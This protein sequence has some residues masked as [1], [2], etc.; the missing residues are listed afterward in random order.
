MPVVGPGTSGR[1]PFMIT[2]SLRRRLAALSLSALL[3][4]PAILAAQTP[5]PPD[6]DE[7][8][9]IQEFFS[10]EAVYLQARNQV[11][12][13]LGAQSH[14]LSGMAMR[15]LPVVLEF[16]L[17]D[18]LQI[19]GEFSLFPASSQ[20][21]AGDSELEFG[22]LFGVRRDIHTL[23]IAAGFDAGMPV[24][25]EGMSFEPFVVVARSLGRLQIHASAGAE[26]GEERGY[27][28]GAAG[29]LPVGPLRLTLEATRASLDGGSMFV[30]PG[31]IWASPFGLEIGAGLPI[32]IRGF[33]R[34]SLVVLLTYEVQL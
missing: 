28:V 8:E 29:I 17:S 1:F 15:R 5:A 21:P 24:G 27:R 2:T 4:F 13:T 9:L 16:G 12:F 11:Q 30:T 32:D 22:L 3:A 7:D 26:L 23:A 18:R 20:G 10:S 6:E 25:A 33:V 34:R 31:L 14:S 19:N